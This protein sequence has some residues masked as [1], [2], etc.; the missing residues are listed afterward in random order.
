[1]AVQCTR[2]PYLSPKV[3]K[4][5]LPCSS[6]SSKFDRDI[7]ERVRDCE[8]AWAILDYH[9]YYAYSYSYSYYCY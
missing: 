6:I 4:S 8:C 1:M 7:Y 5:D 9:Y 2:S 3:R